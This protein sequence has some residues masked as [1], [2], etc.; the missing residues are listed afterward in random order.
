MY[1]ISKLVHHYNH[2]NP[3]ME[4]IE[5]EIYS[6][7]KAANAR[8]SQLS[9]GYISMMF[10]EVVAEDQEGNDILKMV[11]YPIAECYKAVELVCQDLIKDTDSDL[12]F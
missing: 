9:K 7:L 3:S 11:E 8:I 10:H 6:T 5:D 1:I 12:P 2:A 4:W